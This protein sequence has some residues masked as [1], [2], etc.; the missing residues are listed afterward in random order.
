MVMFIRTRL[1]YE[2]TRLLSDQYGD[3]SAIDLKQRYE[4]IQAWFSGQPVYGDISTAVYP[5]A[6]YIELWPFL[7]HPSFAFV[8]SLWGISTVFCLGLMVYGLVRGVKNINFVEGAFIALFLLAT[9]STG[10]VI[11]NGQLT[12]HVLAALLLGITFIC[13][14]KATFADELVGSVLIIFA[15]VKPT[16][17]VPFLPI[18]L[19]S[20]KSWRP[21][22]MV[23]LGYLAIAWLA[24][25]FQDGNLISLHLDWLNRGMEGAVWS[26]S[27]GGADGG[28]SNKGKLG[29][30][31]LHNWLGALGLSQWNLLATL[32]SLGLFTYWVYRYRFV[33]TW[34]LLG[35]A[36]LV[37]RLCTYH[38][39]Y[40][41]LLVIFP[42][43]AIFRF[44]KSYNSPPWLT[45]L[46]IAVL[47]MSIL[48]A[49]LPAR[50]LGKPFPW[51]NLFHIAQTSSWIVLLVFLVYL[52][53]WIKQRNSLPQSHPV[54]SELS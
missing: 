6:S 34:I 48:V 36:A 35:V 22:V 30:G 9:Y 27:G 2:M 37:T 47:S 26:S 13:R 41:D 10:V 11:G 7:H 29:Y 46:S 44:L 39:V 32:I 4:E 20:A 18:I 42:L 43:F 51:F 28:G 40:D 8:R 45:K 16:L 52:A 54:F 3:H 17:A 49:L 19:F 38:L 12:I 24:T 1:P 33:D 5:P 53:Q 21:I 23:S 14:E 50:F 31:N 15:L 25:L